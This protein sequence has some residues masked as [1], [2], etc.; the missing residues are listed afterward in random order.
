[1]EHAVQRLDALLTRERTRV[2]PVLLFGAF[3]VVLIVSWF[4]PGGPVPLP[5]FTARWTAGRLL[6]DGVGPGLYDPTIQ[7][8]VQA[9]LGATRL[10]W[11]VSPPFVAAIFVPLG[12]LPYPV[13]CA[14]WA[15]LLTLGLV[16]SVWIVR[17]WVVLPVG[18]SW[19]IVLVPFL[20][21][22]PL[23]E[24]IGS[25]Q[26]TGFVL[27]VIVVGWA[28]LRGDHD[29]AA[30]MVLAL[31][32][33]KP[34]LIVLVPVLLLLHRRGR[35]LAGFVSMGFALG[36]LSVALVGVDGIVSWLRVANDPLFV[37]EVQSGQAWK[38]VSVPGFLLALLPPGSSLVWQLVAYAAG[39]LLVVAA[40]PAMLRSDIRSLT[41]WAAAIATTLVASPH[42]MVYD[43]VLAL[44]ILVV[45]IVRFWTPKVRVLLAFTFCILWLTPVIHIL[46]TQL[47]WPF[48][49]LGAPWGAVAIAA[50]WWLV[51][52][53]LKSLDGVARV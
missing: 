14:V 50:I 27:L 33:A 6:L 3:L 21:S 35:A 43:L 47:V 22:Y 28:L 39:L 20:A 16:A 5:D 10:S 26:D 34:H 25:G 40:V 30:G 37:A 45:L 32:L 15:L 42:V 11:F 13:A 48:S 38:S 8:N 12:S 41:P 44:P 51:T 17:R 52:S 1:M 9:G 19:G 7:S 4:I 2:Y 46:A 53:R 31:G 23:L 18:M 36:V 29:W 24:L 49:G